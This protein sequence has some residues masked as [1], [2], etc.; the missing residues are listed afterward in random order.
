MDE[1]LALRQLT[2]ADRWIEKVSVQQAHLPEREELSRVET[3]LRELALRMRATKDERDQVAQVYA[4]VSERAEGLRRRRQDL[5]RTLAAATGGAKEL[6][7][8]QH[9]VDQ[10]TPLASAAEDEEIAALLALEAANEAVAAVQ[11]EAEPLMAR[12]VELIASLA[13]L[14]ESLGEELAT[15]RLQRETLAAAVPD[16]L[17]ARYQRALQRAGTSGAAVVVAGRCDGC[18]IALAPADLDRFHREAAT[19]WIECAECGRLLLEESA[20]I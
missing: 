19:S 2:D 4:S 20:E 6:A 17:L 7:A 16:A 9:E 10:L 13:A 15:L 14:D 11:G 5:S 3:T 18:R 8:L 1:R 12:R